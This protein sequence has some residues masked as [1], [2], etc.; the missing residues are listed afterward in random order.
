[1]SDF[2]PPIPPSPPATPSGRKRP[3]F[4]STALWWL[5]FFDSAWSVEEIV[6]NIASLLLIPVCFLGAAG[7]AFFIQRR[8]G[9]A[10]AMAG[11][12]AVLL[13]VLAAVPFPV[14]GTAFGAAMLAWAKL[15]PEK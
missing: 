3:P 4:E 7:P 15:K 11:A 10:F 6:M 14:A 8:A 9:D 1:M 12:K 2:P 13:G 5:V